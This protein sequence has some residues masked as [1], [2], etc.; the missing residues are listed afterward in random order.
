LEGPPHEKLTFS[1]SG[2]EK[3]N[4]AFKRKKLEKPADYLR[5][6][7]SEQR[8]MKKKHI[9]PLVKKY[10]SL[11]NLMMAAQAEGPLFLENFTPKGETTRL[12]PSL[13]TSIHAALS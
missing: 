9:E 11:K 10:G 3:F 8:G 1:V 2:A 13:S 4:L 12:G 5:A 6:L 7:I